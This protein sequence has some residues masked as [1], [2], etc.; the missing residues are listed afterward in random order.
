MLS[1]DEILGMWAEG[2]PQAPSR[3]VLGSKKVVDFARAVERAAY[4]RA[5]QECEPHEDDDSI[6]R[7]TKR[8]LAER[9][10]ALGR[11]HD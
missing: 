11:R 9:I 10:L 3:P 8:E 4:E 6:D 7:Q 5:A 1:D 2:R